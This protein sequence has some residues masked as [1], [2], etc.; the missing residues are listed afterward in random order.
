M[1]PEGMGQEETQRPSTA[2]AAQILSNSGNGF[3]SME[4]S[5]LDIPG[6]PRVKRPF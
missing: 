2:K 3:F 5:A 1:W 6:P 4:T